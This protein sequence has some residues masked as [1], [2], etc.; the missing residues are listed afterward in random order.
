MTYKEAFN[1]VRVMT[2]DQTRLA[3]MQATDK[4]LRKVCG[5][6]IHDYGEYRKTLAAVCAAENQSC[7]YNRMRSHKWQTYGRPKVTLAELRE[8]MAQ[9][10]KDAA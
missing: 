5:W 2:Y 8:R 1:A 7:E 10:P 3:R 4:V 6:R 9:D